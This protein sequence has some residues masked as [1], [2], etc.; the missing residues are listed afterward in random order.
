MRGPKP[1]SGIAVPQ[2]GLS[3]CYPGG[4]VEGMSCSCEKKS[5]RS[6]IIQCLACGRTFS[7]ACAAVI[8]CCRECAEQAQDFTEQVKHQKEERRRQAK[9]KRDQVYRATVKGQR[10]RNAG[11]RRS[12]QRR[13][14]RRNEQRREFL[15]WH[16]GAD[17]PCPPQ[18]SVWND[19]LVVV[20]PEW[21]DDG[22]DTTDVP[23]AIKPSQPPHKPIFQR[24]ES[25]Q[26]P[27]LLP[28]EPSRERPFSLDH[29]LPMTINHPS[30]RQRNPLSCLRPGCG[31]PFTFDARAPHKKFCSKFCYHRI[32]TVRKR[33]RDRFK[34]TRCPLVLKV[35]KM[36]RNL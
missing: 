4:P 36:L 13:K 7:T 27:V 33:L 12:Y 29:A 6:G 11:H 2:F 14:E 22:V 20:Q 30:V 23:P 1:L 9:K 10:K 17:V 28:P 8:F 19:A 15:G 24:P 35:L 34:K 3:D 25:S 21:E 31:K 32:R 26:E 16:T 5:N 18:S